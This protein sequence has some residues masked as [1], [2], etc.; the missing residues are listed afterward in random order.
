MAE[1]GGLENKK[2]PRKIIRIES[3]EML[4]NGASI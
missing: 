4:M 3:R 1:K 2:H